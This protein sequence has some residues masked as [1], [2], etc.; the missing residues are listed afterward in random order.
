MT[1][2]SLFVDVKTY[3]IK[4]T[5]PKIQIGNAKMKLPKK[6]A[7]VIPDSEKKSDYVIHLRIKI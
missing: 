6:V 2:D 1:I 7:I 5:I 4:L 3:L